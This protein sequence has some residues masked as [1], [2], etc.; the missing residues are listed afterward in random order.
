[1]DF[2]LDLPS[3]IG[4]QHK[5]GRGQRKWAGRRSC[6]RLQEISDTTN[7]NVCVSYLDPGLNKPTKILHS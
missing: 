1:M 3:S 4:K 6:S 5:K 7:C 2:L